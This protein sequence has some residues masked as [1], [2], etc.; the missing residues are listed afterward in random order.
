MQSCGLLLSSILSALALISSIPACSGQALGFKMPRASD[1]K[2]D[3]SGIWQA[4]NTA[5]WDLQAHASA[6]GAVASLGAIGGV[7]PGESVVEGGTI[8]YL[9]AAA[10][11]Q[12]EN[13]KRRWIDDPELK[14][15]M[16]G[17]P[18]AN[19]LPYPFQIVQGTNTILMTYE[20]AGAVRTIRMG[21][22]GQSPS[23]SWMG[24]SVGHWDGDTLVVDVTSFNDQ[25]WFDRAGDFHSDALHVVERYTLRSPDIM[26][27]EATIEDPNVFSRPWKISM[28]LYRHVEK[29]AHL[30]EYQCIPYA[31]DI[32]YGHLRHEKEDSK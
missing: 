12:K 20:Y 1:G 29:N 16:P 32:L 21:N 7:P 6:S 19:Y 22:P 28:P 4:L 2:P 8:P 13:Y 9:P 17:V 23:D 5:N 31:E 3:L 15:F 26:D 30:M 24:W 25:T 18:R 14:C 10:S 27:Y 11:K